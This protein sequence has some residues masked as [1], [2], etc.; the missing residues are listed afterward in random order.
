MEMIT[1]YPCAFIFMSDPFAVFD[2]VTQRLFAF[3]GA[4]GKKKVNSMP[5]LIKIYSSSFLSVFQLLNELEN[6]FRIG[7]QLV[8]LILIHWRQTAGHSHKFLLLRTMR[9]SITQIY[10]K[11]NWQLA[12]GVRRFDNTF[13]LAC[14]RR[15][16]KAK[17]AQIASRIVDRF[18]ILFNRA[19]QFS[20]R[21]MKAF[22]KP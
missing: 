6:I 19:E 12:Y 2:Q 1:P 11:S 9:F 17:A 18:A 7:R 20:H 21:A 16:T 8:D 10:Q 3:P 4:A 14:D 22:A 15:K 5:G 13:N